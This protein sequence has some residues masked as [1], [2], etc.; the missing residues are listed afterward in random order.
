MSHPTEPE[1]P[2]NGA[3]EAAH[4]HDDGPLYA[5]P[6]VR[7]AVAFALLISIFEVIYHAVA[8][9]SAAFYKLTHTLAQAAGVVLEPFYDRVTV[10]SARVSTNKFVVTV[11]YG[12][13]GIQ[14][15]TLLMAAVLAFPST[16]M[17]KVVGVVGGVLWLQA[18]NVMRVATLVAVGGFDRKLFEPTHIYIWP[19]LLVVICL[20]TLMAWARWTLSDDELA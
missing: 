15:C 17:Q 19:T 1:N 8:L 18:W 11:D 6:W 9:E 13:D 10:S 12:C 2:G 4:A 5:Q 7:F 16:V 14:V 20:A 3:N